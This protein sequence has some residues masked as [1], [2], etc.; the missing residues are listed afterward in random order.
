M[1][2]GLEAVS[3]TQ[4]VHADGS[5]GTHSS[6]SKKGK[7]YGSLCVCLCVFSPSFLLLEMHYRGMLSS[8]TSEE[9]R[10][11]ILVFF[12]SFHSLRPPT[13]PIDNRFDLSLISLNVLFFFVIT[14]NQTGIYRVSSPP[15][16]RAFNTVFIF[17]HVE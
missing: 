17:D 6:E 10:N 5:H 2:S 13:F 16:S 12:L 14:T 8:V 9:T 3:P 7:R 15:Q 11:Q 4:R 1:P